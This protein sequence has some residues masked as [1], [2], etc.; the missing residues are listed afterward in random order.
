MDI[1]RLTSLGEILVNRKEVV[2]ETVA[3][4]GN[5]MLDDLFRRGEQQD[6]PWRCAI[7]VGST[8][9]EEVISGLIILEPRLEEGHFNGIFYPHANCGSDNEACRFTAEML[10]LLDVWPNHEALTQ[11][12]ISFD[13]LRITGLHEEDE[14]KRL[15]HDGP[16]IEP[17]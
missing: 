1:M 2:L 8:R 7:L 4:T 6:W 13:A 10:A 12:V 3:L 5:G 15:M 17:F 9:G 16:T 11:T 14:A